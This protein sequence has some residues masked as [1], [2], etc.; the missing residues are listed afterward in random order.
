MALA[1][2]RNYYIQISDV[3]S[4]ISITQ[5]LNKHEKE[6]FLYSKWKNYFNCDIDFFPFVVCL[7]SYKYTF[8]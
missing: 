2:E 5:A 3:N 6:R 1:A 8:I 4:D 7:C